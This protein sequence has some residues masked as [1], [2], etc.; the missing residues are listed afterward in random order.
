[1]ASVETIN[2]FNL[3]V[4]GICIENEHL[5][6]SDEIRMDHHMTKLPGGGLE[7]GEGLEACLK[8]EWQEELEVEI[9]VGEIFFVN[10]FLLTSA[11]NPRDQVLCF[12]YPVR[13][14]HQPRA[15]FS[16]QAH[17]FQ[18]EKPGDQ[19]VFRWAAL[20]KLKPEDFTFPT[21]RTLLPRIQN[22]WKNRNS[23]PN[24]HSFFSDK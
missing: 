22:A 7:F 9:A 23:H 4:Y 12:Y 3:R 6:L 10:P 24:L 5:L 21:D 1:M 14:L 8:R 17:D 13:M 11:F 19:Q 20:A 2:R 15:L 18:R 16:E